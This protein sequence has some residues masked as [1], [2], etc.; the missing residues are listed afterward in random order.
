MNFIGTCSFCPIFHTDVSHFLKGHILRCEHS[1]KSFQKYIRKK[2]KRIPPTPLVF[3]IL[4]KTM[5][6]FTVLN[7]TSPEHF[8]HSKQSEQ[9]Q[10]LT[11]NSCCVHVTSVSTQRRQPGRTDPSQQ[12]DQDE[13]QHVRTTPQAGLARCRRQPQAGGGTHPLRHPPTSPSPSH[14]PTTN[15]PPRVVF[16]LGERHLK[17]DFEILKRS[18]LPPS[19]D[20]RGLLL[21]SS[22]FS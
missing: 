12:S 14:S 10:L 15:P 4:N 2:K 21:F 6:F 18:L 17:K 3:C 8:T 1:G 9:L 22:F 7:R 19:G 16:Q 20:M 11:V 5:V 13:H